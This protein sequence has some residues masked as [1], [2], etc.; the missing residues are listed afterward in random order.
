MQ[1]NKIEVQMDY[2]LK[3]NLSEFDVVYSYMEMFENDINQ[4]WQGTSFADKSY[5][6][7]FGNNT[8]DFQS[9]ML[10]SKRIVCPFQ[11]LLHR[12]IV[13]KIGGWNEQLLNSMDVEFFTK[14]M[15]AAE[16]IIYVEGTKCYYR[17]TPN[18][19][20]KQ[21]KPKDCEFR[22]VALTTMASIML[23]NNFSRQTINALSYYF[24]YYITDWFPANKPTLK[25]LEKFMKENNIA[26]NTTGMSKKHKF[27]INTLG[28]RK[29]FLLKR[30]L[31]GILK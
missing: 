11:Y 20:S 3:Q 18:S 29:T 8:L 21:I 22:L 30:K 24:D 23:K 10:L 25:R 16:N 1:P 13:E 31:K 14:I 12:K 26:Y 9:D 2:I 4:S 7:K 17:A 15:E 27:L 28:W 6:K 5:G 19:M